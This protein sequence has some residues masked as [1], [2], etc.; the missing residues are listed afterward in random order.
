VTWWANRMAKLAHSARPDRGIPSQ[1][2]REHVERVVRGAVDR[3]KLATAC[4]PA[5]RAPLV[6]VAR[7]AAEFHDLGKLD[8]ENQRILEGTGGG[9]L[10]HN[11]VDAGVA[12]LLREAGTHGAGVLAA[13]TIF[14]HHRG[15][16]CLPE[17]V[18]R[19]HDAFRDTDPL[20]DGRPARLLTD[21]LLDRYLSDHETETTG[22]GPAAPLP[23]LSSIAQLLARMALSCL[24]DADH[25]DTSW[26]YRKPVVEDVPDV[27]GPE[28]L[29]ALDR[30]VN[31]LAE[32]RDD[33]RTR[34]RNTVYEACRNADVEPPLRECDS[35]VG[36]GKTT[37]VMAHLLRVACRKGFRRVFVVLPYT[38]I[39]DQSVNVYRRA[40]VLPDENPESVVAAHHHRASYQDV[41]A[42][43]LAAQW[44]APV[45]VTTAVQFFET[46]AGRR[47]SDLRKLH[48]VPG[49]AIFIDESH[50]C[51]P[52]AL[53]PQAWDW[54]TQLVTDWGC[55]IVLGSGS[56][57]RLWTLPEFSSRPI[58]VPPLIRPDVALGT[59]EAERRR[60]TYRSRPDPLDLQ[61]FV[62][63]LRRLAGPRLVIVN[64][65]QTSAAL[66]RLLA[67]ILGRS[68]V[69]HM[70]TALTPH[71]RAVVLKRIKR[72]LSNPD[73]HDWTLV[74]T[75]CVEAGVDFSFRTGLR[76]RAGLS[77]LIQLGGRVN[78]N[79]EFG[80]GDVW[81]FRLKIMGLVRPNPGLR[82]AGEVLGQLIAE[83]KLSPEHCTEALR[84]EVRLSRLA[85]LNGPLRRAEETHDYPTVETLF[86]VID[87]PT[88][89]VVVDLDLQN[90]LAAGEPVDW[91]ELQQDSV[92]IDVAKGERLSLREFAS[93][94]GVKGWTLPYDDFLGVMAGILRQL[95]SP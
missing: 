49:S 4:S 50:A 46:L 82:D 32:G 16:P 67:E 71:D 12:H 86:Q 22:L 64:T 80:Q 93:L 36:S 35:P 3:A 17:Q 6:A 10:P 78:R 73:D 20:D 8:S 83:G 28:R 45:V 5:F 18:T 7:W 23:A 38:T 15:L 63:W 65:V 75:S 74:A 92:Q 1:T 52:S 47:P 88:I 60:I 37:A 77:N 55:H 39:I 61:H 25:T 66:A 84:C 14:S 54:L 58:E 76:E 41:Q 59:S 94:P 89:T 13:M 27:R 85:E 44:Q 19:R 87:R 91:R 51:L 70:S 69:E 56:L 72:R 79:A 29:E 33:N 42:R 21:A 11:H 26:H 53:W 81:D 95:D 24:A 30:Y 43:H 31:G 62:A 90:R 48:Q 34:L 9:S 40:L 57:N 68:Q 2:Y